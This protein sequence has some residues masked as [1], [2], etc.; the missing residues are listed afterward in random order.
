MM[1]TIEIINHLI[2]KICINIDL[3]AIIGRRHSTNFVSIGLEN[4]R[5]LVLKI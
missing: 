1:M 5:G 3:I 2:C 4:R